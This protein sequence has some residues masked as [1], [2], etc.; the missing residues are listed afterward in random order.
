MS[1]SLHAHAVALSTI[2]IR[3]STMIARHQSL[4]RWGVAVLALSIQSAFA[5]DYYV[6]PN[7]WGDGN[8]GTSTLFPWK[9]LDKVNAST[10]QNGDRVLFFKGGSWEGTLKLK[11][12][13]SYGSY[14]DSSTAAAPVIRAS[15]NVGALSWTLY[16]GNIWRA[17]VTNV[18]RSGETDVENV[19]FQPNL[20]QLIYN[21]T[22]LQRAR[23]PNP[24]NGVFGRG[25]NRYLRV[26]AGTVST[27]SLNQALKV[28]ANALP[29]SVT[30][31]DLAGAQAFSRNFPWYLTRYD[32]T[33]SDAGKTTL[34]L[35][36]D[37]TWPGAKAY[38]LFAGNGYW[39]ENKLWM[40]DQ[41]GEWVYDGSGTTK[42][43]YVWLPG[44]ANP[45][46]KDL[47]AA[48]RV[49]A[50]EGRN[51]SNVT[52]ANLV[53]GESRGD[54]LAITGGSNITIDHMSVLRAGA[55]GV[56]VINTGLSGS[57]GKVSNSLVADSLSSGIYLG[58]NSTL[59]FNIENNIVNNAGI[60]A[61]T[62]AAIWSGHGSNVQG[63]VVDHSNYLGIRLGKANTVCDNLVTNSCMEF[64]DCGAIYSRGLDYDATA[65][66]MSARNDVGGMIQNN[67]LD[68]ALLANAPDRLDGLPNVPADVKNSA[69][70]GLYFDDFA[71]N[72]SATNN[73]VTGFDNGVLL[74]YGRNNYIAGNTLVNNSR[75]QVFM[76]ENKTD[77][78][79]H[80]DTPE[81]CGTQPSCDA[82]NYMSGNAVTGNIMASSQP[83]PT[84]I[85]TSGFAGESDFG[86]FS[87]NFYATYG[88]TQFATVESNVPPSK[89]FG[90][91][92]TAFTEANS[93][94]FATAPSVKA[95]AG[96]AN[97][98]AN[99]DFSQSFTNW[100][101]YHAVSTTV[102]SGCLNA[103]CLTTA[104]SSDAGVVNGHK[105][106]IVNTTTP[107]PITAGQQF[108]V[109]FDAQAANAGESL[110]TVLRSLD[111]QDMYADKTNVTGYNL[112][113][114]WQ[115]YSAVLTAKASANVRLDFE[116]YANGTVKID[117]VRLVPA[118]ALSGN[119][120]P[121]GF[122]N[123]GSTAKVINCPVTDATACT[124]YVEL[125]TKTPIAF[126]YSLPAKS[127]I[128]VVLN[129]PL[130]KDTDVDG[131][132]GETASTGGTDRCANT[133]DG[134]SVGENG[135]AIGQ[136]PAP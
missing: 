106:F 81:F 70:V 12:G 52:V 115:T 16:S 53:V 94:V 35:T 113:T 73:Y 122:Y 118:Q 132:P 61:Y 69:T 6:N 127:S 62:L 34:N 25:Q 66:G 117:N 89:T 33:S 40:L 123:W 27:E 114:S 120:Q 50:I 65:Y 58:A 130:W 80:F 136:T 8:S 2:H 112:S 10:F 17:N 105:V 97:K 26:G 7:S 92:K 125:K 29:A 57:G 135:C 100:G 1:F 63:N 124:K 134:A 131:V 15:T 51:V 48:N 31:A 59:H 11:S 13:V 54:A 133:P 76:Q 77:G 126:P 32:V 28:E 3:D 129:D 107:M 41:P 37:G 68:G 56:K 111:S 21:G 18:V 9:T 108:I 121:Y 109:S 91:W 60:G 88:T 87:G 4:R 83:N 74:H 36:A 24:G 84:L 96:A 103:P 45:N 44:N 39:L 38:P 19:A 5:T 90:Q 67:Y 14:P 101:D 110:V 72:A 64:D 104:P 102:G 98:I 46:G 71:G 79:S 78:V 47:F 30:A 43:L 119:A 82:N 99:G 22:R 116:L 49:H 95:V 55:M 93:T 128:V 42:Y 75:T 20:T 85:L 86:S 23:Y